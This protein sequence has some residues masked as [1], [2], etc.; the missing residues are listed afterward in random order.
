MTPGISRQLAHQVEAIVE[1]GPGREIAEVETVRLVRD[2]GDAR[3]AFGAD[4]VGDAGDRE[5]PVDGL[6]ARHRDG[7]VEQ[8]LERDVR[9]CGDGLADRHRPGM[10]ESPVAEV[11]EHVSVPVEL[12]SRDPVDA[13]AAHLD[14][15]LGLAVHPV[16]HEVTA[17][18]GQGR[19]P[20]GQARRRVVRAAGAEPGHAGRALDP[21][22]RRLA[23]DQLLSAG[24]EAEAGELGVQA[25]GD[26]AGELMRRQFADPGHE[27]LL[28]L[29]VLAD[30]AFGFPARIV[31]EVLL[32]LALDD[33]ALLLDHEHLVLAL[34]ELE[35]AVVLEWPDHADLVDV[36]TD[37]P[38]L[39]PVDAEQAQCFHQVEMTL[40]GGDDP[41]AR[42]RDVEDLPVDR[43]LGSE[44]ERRGLLRL[45][46]FLD[47]RTGEVGPAV[48]QAARRHVEIWRHETWH[49]R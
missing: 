29:V 10:I 30:H 40:A 2:H 35:R 36:E 23:G 46:P 1:G 4:R 44:G 5:R 22:R 14:Q 41:V 32:E 24:R 18:A 34:D 3:D 16:G 31:V 25:T 6:A 38:R 33:A 17:D 9:I 11:L 8:D 49:R 26:D 28:E 43:I 39:A 20:F 27:P 15:A 47:L 48:V 42:I 12:R 37:A 21:Y 45:E 13:F 19:R 7:V